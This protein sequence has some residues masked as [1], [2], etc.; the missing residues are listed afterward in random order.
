MGTRITN[1]STPRIRIDNSQESEYFRPKN[2]NCL[3]SE[4]R[5]LEN[6]CSQATLPAFYAGLRQ[7]AVNGMAQLSYRRVPA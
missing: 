5:M 7:R 1:D 3:T 4:I 6:R 2:T